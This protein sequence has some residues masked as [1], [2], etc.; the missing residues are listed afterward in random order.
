MTWA[1]ARA[2]PSH[3]LWRLSSKRVSFDKR[4]NFIREGLPKLYYPLAQRRALEYAYS[5]LVT[6]RASQ[7]DQER[8]RVVI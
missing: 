8:V 5:A 1:R 4:T 3:H 2:E 7:S 6:L